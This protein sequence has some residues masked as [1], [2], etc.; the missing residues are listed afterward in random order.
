MDLSRRG[1][2]RIADVLA[3]GAPIAEGLCFAA[4]ILK[5]ALEGRSHYT[6]GSVRD[7]VVGFL[8]GA[9]PFL[10]LGGIALGAAALILRTRLRG[11][12][13]LGLLSAVLMVP[14]SAGV[15]LTACD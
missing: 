15:A 3:I 8:A 5:L 11:A 9:L 2:Q 6:C 12:A 7:L 10:S 4:I 13:I 1:R 14:V